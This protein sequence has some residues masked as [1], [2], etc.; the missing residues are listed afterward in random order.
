MYSG[1]SDHSAAAVQAKFDRFEAWLI[2]NGARFDHVS[3][4]FALLD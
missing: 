1:N 3:A 4:L 2:S